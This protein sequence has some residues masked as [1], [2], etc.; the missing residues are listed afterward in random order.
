ML[1]SLQRGAPEWMIRAVR[2]D[3]QSLG[4]DFKGRQ[5]VNEKTGRLE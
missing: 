5:T 2:E 4:V 1:I 3:T